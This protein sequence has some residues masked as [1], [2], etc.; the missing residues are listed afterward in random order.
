VNQTCHSIFEG[1][2]MT[3]SLKIYILILNWLHNFILS[4][5]YTTFSVYT[6]HIQPFQC[7]LYIY[8]LFSVHCTY[9]T[10]SVYTVHKIVYIIFSFM[11]AQTDENKTIY[12]FFSV[13]LTIKNNWFSV[14]KTGISNLYLIRQM[15]KRHR[16]E[17]DISLFIWMVTLK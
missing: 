9:T 12:T 4:N 14:I 2:E 13:Y 15:F 1:S 6:V 10:F 8:N 5:T 17:W 7:T 3:S 16:C 11:D